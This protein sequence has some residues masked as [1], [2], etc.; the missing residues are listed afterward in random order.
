MKKLILALIIFA[1]PA[2]AQT[3]TPNP[4]PR[5]I[6]GNVIQDFKNATGQNTN[7][8]PPTDAAFGGD[9]KIVQLLAKPFNDLANFINS[10]SLAAA[11]LAIAIPELQDGNGQQCWL[12]MG[13]FTAVLKAHPIP[14][15][16]HA[17]TDLEALRLAAM[18][19]NNVCK[20]SSCTQ[21][22][23]DLSNGIQQVAPIN[24]G[25]AIPSLNS[26]CSKVP[27]VTVAPTVPM[28]AS[29]PAPVAPPASPPANP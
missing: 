25:I 13:Q 23:A 6:T 18:A 19:A 14:I 5:P 29:V 1:S 4:K 11:Q 26:L 10:D 22:F 8:A 27:V 21:V 12:A 24:A 16:L 28:P 17:M 2:F 9:D 15:T 20:N 7:A 3:S